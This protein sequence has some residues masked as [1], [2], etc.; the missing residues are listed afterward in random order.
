MGE[1]EAERWKRVAPAIDGFFLRF[2]FEKF[3]R[4][5]PE[6]SGHRAFPRTV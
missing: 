6:R 5:I 2:P 3:C 4:R 1:G